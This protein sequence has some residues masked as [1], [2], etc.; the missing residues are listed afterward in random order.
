[1]RKLPLVV[2]VFSAVAAADQSSVKSLNEKRGKEQQGSLLDKYAPG[3]KPDTVKEAL[4][5][6]AKS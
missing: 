5:K 4:E 3:S 2:G 6:T 1:M